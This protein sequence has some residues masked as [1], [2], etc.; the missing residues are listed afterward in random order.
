MGLQYITFDTSL[1]RGLTYY[2]GVIFEAVLLDNNV[3]VGSIA[4]GGRYDGL[5]G[6]FNNGTQIPAVG[7]SIG[8]ERIFAYLEAQK[9]ET[10]ESLTNTKCYVTYIRDRKDEN[11]NKKHF[12]Q[13]LTIAKELWE[14]GVPTE[15]VSNSKDIMKDQIGNVIKQGIPVMIIVAENELRDDCVNVKDIKSNKQ[16][17]THLSKVLE[18]VQNKL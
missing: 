7:C 18:Y 16:Q 13:V 4:A 2:T 15:I 8:V 9:T 1:C 17:K 5:I 11:K 12:E 6:M 3:G 14:N 10:K